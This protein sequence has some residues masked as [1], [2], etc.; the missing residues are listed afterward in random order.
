MD[1]TMSQAE[2]ADRFFEKDSPWQAGLNELRRIVRATGLAEEVKWGAPCYTHKG[3]NVVMIIATKGYF[4]LWFYKG[5]L[6]KD[7]KKLLS[8]ADTKTQGLRQM[9]FTE[10]PTVRKGEAHIK[11]Y[12]HEAALLEEQG[13]KVVMKAVSAADMPAEWKQATKATPGLQ[14]AFSALTPGRQRAYMAHF[15]N[16]KQSS[17]RTAR[18]EKSVDLILAGKG[19]DGK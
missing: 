17:T 8:Q 16:A 14:K 10:L 4:G 3:R 7:A 12:I 2:K 9:R 1:R 6:L 13:A 11:A 15:T 5:S 18:I 19:M